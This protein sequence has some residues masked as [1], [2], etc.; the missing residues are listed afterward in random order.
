MSTDKSEIKAIVKKE[1]EEHPGDCPSDTCFFQKPPK[2][3]GCTAVYC[4]GCGYFGGISDGK[5]DTCYHF[6]RFVGLGVSPD[7]KFILV[8]V[9]PTVQSAYALFH[10]STNDTT[11]LIATTMFFRDL[12]KKK[13]LPG[14]SQE[15]ATIGQKLAYKS[16]D[17]SAIVVY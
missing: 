1:T 7:Q 6:A 15:D 2:K 16:A 10:T 11:T 12:L 9:R 17:G 5:V 14:I 3:T 4:Y 8:K 13:N